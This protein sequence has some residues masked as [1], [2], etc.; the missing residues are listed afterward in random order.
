[1]PCL[2]G[3]PICFQLTPATVGGKY[4][5][6]GGYGSDGGELLIELAISADPNITVKCT[7]GG[8]TFVAYGNF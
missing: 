8:T 6:Q 4:V 1:L 3:G 2:G 7:A 5:L